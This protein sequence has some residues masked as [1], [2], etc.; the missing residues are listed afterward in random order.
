MEKEKIEKFKKQLEERKNKLEEELSSIAKKDPL[1]KNDYDA[2]FP[3]YG[4]QSSDEEAFEVA[5]YE[6]NLSMEQALEIKLAEIKAAL[7]RIEKGTYGRCENC[8]EEIDEKRLE[9][10]PEAKICVKC[11]K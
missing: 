6:S 4:T 7:E 10:M 9:A 1:V 8:Q 2:K 11:N 5:S 3:D